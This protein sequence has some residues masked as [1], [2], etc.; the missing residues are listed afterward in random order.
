MERDNLNSRESLALIAEVIS[1]TKDNF[2]QHSFVF[3]IWGWALAVASVAR[4]VLQTQTDVRYYFI[5]F[6]VLAGVALILTLIFYRRHSANARLSETHLNFFLRKL[7]LVLILGFI[8]IVFVSVYQHIEPF[9][10]TLI[11]AGSVL[12]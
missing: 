3:L 6:P 4:F 11:L 2:K 10:Y 9:T 8:A 5:P 7:W 12:T 1:Q